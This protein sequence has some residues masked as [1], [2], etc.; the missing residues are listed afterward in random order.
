MLKDLVGSQD[1]FSALLLLLASRRPR[2]GQQSANRQPTVGQQLADSQP[3]I[4]FGNYSSLLPCFFAMLI[5]KLRIFK[6][7]TYENFHSIMFLPLLQP[8]YDLVDRIHWPQFD[9]IGET[10][11][12]N[13]KQVWIF[14]EHC[15]CFIPCCSV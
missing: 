11:V 5:A 13:I 15:Y 3:T 2:A 6:V 7:V 12:I 1:S 14:R 8:F 4:S 9:L 10:S